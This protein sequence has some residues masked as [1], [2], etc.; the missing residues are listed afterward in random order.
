MEVGSVLQA[1]QG[2]TIANQKQV[3]MVLLCPQK[4]NPKKQTLGS[5]C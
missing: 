1:L 4:G 3:M 2:V 5:F